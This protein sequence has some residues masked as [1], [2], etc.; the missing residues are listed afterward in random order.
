MWAVQFQQPDLA[1]A[2]AKRDEIV[3]EDFE[4]L[5]HVAELVRDDYRLP[6]PPQV[7]AA[8]RARPDPGQLFVLGRPLAMVIGAVG[9]AQ[10]RRSLGH[11]LSFTRGVGPTGRQPIRPQRR[12]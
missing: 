3:A 8:R 11:A 6:E 5:R 9:G 2:V 1:T 4:P 10:K 12:R 7:F